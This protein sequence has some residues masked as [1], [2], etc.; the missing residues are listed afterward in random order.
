MA[1]N[2]DGNKAAICAQA[3]CRCRKQRIDWPPKMVALQFPGPC[4]HDGERFAAKW[5]EIGWEGLGE[6]GLDRARILKDIAFC[7]F[8][9]LQP[10]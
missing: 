3:R 1:G 8:D 5:R 10:E 4:V 2:I 9:M 6:F 7:K